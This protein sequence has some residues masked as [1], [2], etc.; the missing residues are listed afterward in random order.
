MAAL[1][2]RAENTARILDVTYRWTLLPQ[3]G[4]GVD[5]MWSGM[6]QGHGA[7]GRLPALSRL[8]HRGRAASS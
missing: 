2:E 6:R 8:Q 3:N 7:A 5:N 1:L 4:E